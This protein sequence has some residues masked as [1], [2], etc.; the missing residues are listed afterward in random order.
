M[1]DR[2]HVVMA[3]SCRLRLVTGVTAILVATLRVSDGT[4]VNAADGVGRT[5]G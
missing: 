3:T 2:P 1:A 5:D 4:T